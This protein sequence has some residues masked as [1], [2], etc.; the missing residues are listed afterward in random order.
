MGK[1]IQVSKDGNVAWIINNRPEAL[2]AMRVEVWQELNAA[3]D[4]LSVDPDVRVAIIA[5]EGRAFCAGADVKEMTEHVEEF[6]QKSVPLTLLRQWQNWLQDSTRKIRSA[7][8]PVIAAVHGYAVGAGCE[9]CMACDLIVAEAG[10]KLGFP[11][12]TVGVTITNGGTFYTPRLLGLAKA[13]EMAYTGEFIDAEE[14]YRLGAVC[15]IAPEGKVREEAEALAKRIASRAPIAVTLHKLMIDRALDGTLEAALN[16][17]TEG[18]FTTAM[19]RDHVE[20]SN[21]WVDKR[22]PKFEGN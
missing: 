6:G 19:S 14:A 12:A 11:E 1:Q 10:A 20:G 8:F 18:I 22:N 16:Y 9:L 3:I 7:Q 13:R 2:N 17:E 5:G 15:R 21:A 4:E